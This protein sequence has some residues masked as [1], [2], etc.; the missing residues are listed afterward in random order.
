[1]EPV[2]D[3]ANMKVKGSTEWEMSWLLM[4]GT[5]IIAVSPGHSCGILLP[6]T[7]PSFSPVKI[8]LIDL[9]ICFTAVN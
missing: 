8:L 6:S 5:E 1:M 9:A 7:Q 3:L 4:H 2:Q